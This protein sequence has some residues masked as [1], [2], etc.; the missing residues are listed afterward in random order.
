METSGVMDSNVKLIRDTTDNTPSE[1]GAKITELI[2]E[3]RTI[4]KQVDTILRGYVPA[5]DS[6]FKWKTE[7]PW[8]GAWHYIGKDKKV[9][10]PHT[11][12]GKDVTSYSGM[13]YGTSVSGVYSDNL[14]VTDMSYMF[15]GSLSTSLDLPNLDTNNVADMAAM[16]RYSQATSLDLSSFDTSSVTDMWDMFM[17]SKATQGYARTPSD[18]DRFNSSTCK[19]SGLTFI[20]KPSAS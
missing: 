9:I 7:K 15:C 13:F 16:F 10:I 11:I 2:N 4:K 3:V 19:P 6:D 8:N 5:K 20:V 18:A 1:L 14:N 12:K 17:S